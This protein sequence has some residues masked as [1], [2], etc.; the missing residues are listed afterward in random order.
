MKAGVE[1]GNLRRQRDEMICENQPS[2]ERQTR[3][4]VPGDKRGGGMLR[5]GGGSSQGRLRVK[6]T[7]GGGSMLKGQEA[8]AARQQGRH[9][10]QLANKRPMGGEA[11]A[12]RRRWIVERR[13]TEAARRKDDRGRWMRHDKRRREER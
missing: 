7:R 12:D 5:G 10:N 6:R 8:A 13:E 1:D 3:G 4:E 11:F 9:D 2:K